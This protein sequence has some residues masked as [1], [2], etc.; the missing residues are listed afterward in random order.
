MRREDNILVLLIF[1]AFLILF[2][3]SKNA[4]ELLANMP[5]ALILVTSLILFRKYVGR[6]LK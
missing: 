3:S 1:S 5:T 2:T 6:W 4:R